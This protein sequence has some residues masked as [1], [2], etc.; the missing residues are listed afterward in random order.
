MYDFAASD[1]GGGGEM[2]EVLDTHHIHF[3]LVSTVGVRGG[4]SEEISKNT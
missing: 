2:A 1:R 3:F 4:V